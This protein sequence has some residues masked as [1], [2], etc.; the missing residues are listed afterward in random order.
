MAWCRL[1]QDTADP[2]V[3]Y[4]VSSPVHSA[5]PYRVLHTVEPRHSE[6]GTPLYKGHFSMYQPTCMYI[7]ASK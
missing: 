6:Y 2:K 4:H 5:N 3:T 7:F 1:E